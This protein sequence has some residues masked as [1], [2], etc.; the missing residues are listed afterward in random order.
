MVDIII[1]RYTIENNTEFKFKKDYNKVNDFI[2]FRLICK[3]SDT[4][5]VYENRNIAPQRAGIFQRE[6]TI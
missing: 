2:I 3:W 1:Y 5:G 6:E 4:S